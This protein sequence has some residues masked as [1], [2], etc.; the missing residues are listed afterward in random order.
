MGKRE[1]QLDPNKLTIDIKPKTENQ[2][3][4][5]EALNDWQTQYLAVSGPPGSGKTILTT[6]YAAS[7][8]V[9][10]KVNKVYIARSVTPVRG[11]QLG[12]VPGNLDEKIQG[13]LTPA[14]ENFQKFLPD[15]RGT[16]RRED[17]EFI[18][19]AMVRGRS[20]ENCIVLVEEAQNLS[21]DLFR[22]LLTRIDDKSKIIFSGDFRQNDRHTEVTDFERVCRSLRGMTTFNWIELT[23][24]DIIRSQ[25]IAEINM[26]L[27]RLEFGN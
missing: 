4:L 25:S 2:G 27:D 13:W 7:Q 18:P 6:Y 20:L 17:I 1:K 23:D 3:Y 22:T 15:F 14:L 8:L 9:Q 11:E 5:Q 10:N 26:L 12:F 19:L 16:M 21:L 24:K